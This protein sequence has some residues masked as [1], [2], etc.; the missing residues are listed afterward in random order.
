MAKLT[1]PDELLVTHYRGSIYLLVSSSMMRKMMVE[2]GL[3]FLQRTQYDQ[4]LQ[5][6]AV[7]NDNTAPLH[8]HGR[9][10]LKADSVI[11]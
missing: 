3:W 11:S 9:M 4:I 10:T 7:Y 2:C 1:L 8:Q 5:S 6:S